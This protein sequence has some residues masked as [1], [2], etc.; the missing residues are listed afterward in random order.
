MTAEHELRIL[1]IMKLYYIVL[2]SINKSAPILL[3]ETVDSL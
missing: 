3:L 2:Y 1:M